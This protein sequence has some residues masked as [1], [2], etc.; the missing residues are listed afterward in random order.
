MTNKKLILTVDD[1]AT[2]RELLLSELS[3]L[4]YR[5]TQAEDGIDGLEMLSVEQPDLIITDITMPRMDGIRFIQNVR[6][7]ERYKAT[8]ILVLTTESDPDIKDRAKRAGATGWI[9]KPFDPQKLA[10]AIRKVTA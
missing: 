8:P 5:V 7:D 2:I 9:V 6:G 4:G 1:S 10:E 3:C